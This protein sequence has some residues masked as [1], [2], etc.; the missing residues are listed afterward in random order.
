METPKPMVAIG[1]FT[2]SIPFTLRNYVTIQATCDVLNQLYNQI[3]REEN[4]ATYGCHAGYSLKRGEKDEYEVVFTANCE[5]QPEKCDSVLTLMKNTF[6]SMAQDVNETMVRNAK[7]T[8]LNSFESLVKTSN[9]FWLDA[10]WIKEDQ[11]MDFY[12]ER[13]SLIEQITPDDIKNF[14]RQLLSDSHFCEVLMQ[15]E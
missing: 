7:E 9:G 15:P 1:W 11:G 3:V 13:Q 8:L 12:T 10:I 5:M 14:V 2:E 6:T 4:S